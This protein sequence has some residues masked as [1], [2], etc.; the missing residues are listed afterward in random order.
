[1]LQKNIV[2]PTFSW[3]ILAVG[4]SFSMTNCMNRQTLTS[5]DYTDPEAIRNEMLNKPTKDK[6]RD[7]QLT[8]CLGIHPRAGRN[9]PL[10]VLSSLPI[11]LIAE[12]YKD[13]CYK[14]LL[15]V[16]YHDPAAQY[17]YF[18]ICIGHKMLYKLSIDKNETMGTL[19]NRLRSVANLKPL[20]FIYAGSFLPE[21]QSVA[22]STGRAFE[23][24]ANNPNSMIFVLE[25][26][27]ITDHS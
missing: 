25:R 14:N 21:N 22:I 27:S 8:L 19:Q 11:K 18:H 10:Q 2:K 5:T 20:I 9:S 7:I 3:L 1:M 12:H 15:P 17:A 23:Y 16:V 24:R 26:D 13:D 4:I 6:A